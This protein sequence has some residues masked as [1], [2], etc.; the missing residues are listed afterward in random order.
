MRGLGVQRDEKNGNLLLQRTGPFAPPIMLT[1]ERRVGQII[2]VTQSF[3]EKLEAANFGILHFK[4]AIKKHI[5]RVHWETWDRKARL[6]QALPDSGE[7]EEYVLGKEHSEQTA[8]EMP[9]IW[10]F[11]P[12]DLSCVQDEEELLSYNSP[13]RITA[14]TGLHNGLFRCIENHLTFV[15]ETGRRWFEREGEGWVDFEEVIVV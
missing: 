14:P 2:L 12:P 8:A 3:R 6:P 10:E 7:P 13:I 9:E 11:D 1:R 15:D 5:V 4:P